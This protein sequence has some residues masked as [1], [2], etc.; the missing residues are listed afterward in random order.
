MGFLFDSLKT[1]LSIIYEAE[2]LAAVVEV[3][4]MNTL[5]DFHIKML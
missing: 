3:G 2:L 4:E 5:S 1:R